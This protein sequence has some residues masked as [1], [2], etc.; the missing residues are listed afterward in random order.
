M[1]VIYAEHKKNKMVSQN[2][3]WPKNNIAFQKC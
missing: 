3:G 2:S 1:R